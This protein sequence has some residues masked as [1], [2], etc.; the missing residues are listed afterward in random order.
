MYFYTHT[1]IYI[2]TQKYNPYCTKISPDSGFITDFQEQLS[3]HYNNFAEKVLL[4]IQVQNCA[5]WFSF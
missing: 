1:H 2:N 3:E 4:E 5:K